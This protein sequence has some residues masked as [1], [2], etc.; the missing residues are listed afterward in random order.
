MSF[1]ASFEQSRLTKATES[2]PRTSIS[3]MCDTPKRPARV[4]VRRC[5][6]TVPAGYCTGMSHPPNS[7][8]RPPRRLCAAIR[9]VCFRVGA[10]TNGTRVL[11]SQST[12]TEWLIDLTKPKPNTPRERASSGRSPHAGGRDFTLS[13]PSRRLILNGPAH[14]LE[15]PGGSE[16]SGEH[17]EATDV[18][19]AVCG[20]SLND[21]GFGAGVARAACARTGG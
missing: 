7:T 14:K 6:S 1:D 2:G 16:S 17:L 12:L 3:P 21:S 15:Y 4:R 20:R 18:D 9:G 13:L 10:V 11:S 8:M 19:E 5:S